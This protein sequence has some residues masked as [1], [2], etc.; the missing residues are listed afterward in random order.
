MFKKQ[1]VNPDLPSVLSNLK[2]DIL[3]SINCINI[4][5]IQAFDITSQ[6]ATIKLS[7]KRII[8]IAAD[9][10][11]TLQERP[12]LLECPCFILSGGGAYINMPI[13][14]GDGC[15]VLFN[16]R[17]IDNWFIGGDD[18]APNT[19]RM[20][21]ISD[22]FALVGIFNSTNF[23]S[24]F[25]ANVLKIQFNSNNKIEMENG[26]IT[27]TSPENNIE[28]NHTIN[29]DSE[30]NGDQKITGD[31]TIKG[32]VDITGDVKITGNLT[33]TGLITAGSIASGAITATGAVAAP[34]LSVNGKDFTSHT[35][36]AG[37]YKDSYSGNVSG[38]SGVLS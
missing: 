31:Q 16:D 34:S 4:G 13:S 23:I 12:L 37:S 27:Q 11:K 20:H 14:E 3:K 26:Q 38:T 36:G 10:S 28:G 9:G 30:I 35:H 6:T 1:I 22:G 19:I 7:I 15:L 32:N 18:E 8:S 2:S 29:G 33:V 21:D 25:L 17:D 5:T 24:D